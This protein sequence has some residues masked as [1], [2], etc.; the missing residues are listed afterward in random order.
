MFWLHT[1]RECSRAV[2]ALP[3]CWKASPKM[4]LQSKPGVLIQIGRLERALLP[5]R[6]F[7]NATH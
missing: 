5:F 4:I 6:A 2:S 7:V 3:A 1:S